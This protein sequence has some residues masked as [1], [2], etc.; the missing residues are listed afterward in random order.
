MS[1]DEIAKWVTEILMSRSC[2]VVLRTGLVIF[3]CNHIL[4]NKIEKQSG[5]LGWCLVC[6]IFKSCKNFYEL[7]SWKGIVFCFVF[8][9]LSIEL[10]NW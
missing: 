1:L 3:S 5:R 4:F 8:F 9:Y 10:E 7:R 2:F 6:S